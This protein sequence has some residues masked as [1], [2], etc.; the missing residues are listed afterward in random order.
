MS[1]RVHLLGTGGTIAGAQPD[2]RHAGYSAGVFPI[3]RLLSAVPGLAELARLSWEQIVN[4]GSQDMD[5]SIWLALA[6]RVNEHADGAAIDALLITHG[7][8]TLEETAYF[9]SLVTAN[10]T[11]VVIVGAMR[12]ATAISADGPGN[13]YN[14]VAVAADP[15][16]PGR[17]TLLCMDGEIHRPRYAV[18]TS[19]MGANAF[20]SL[21]GGLVGVVQTGRVA[22]F[23]PA[24]AIRAATFSVAGLDRLPR[25]DVLIAHAGMNADL[26]DAA[27]AAG[28]RGLVIAGV[29]SGNMSA[30]AIARLADAAA[31]GVAV[32]RSSRVPRSM[33]LRNGE[34]DDDRYGFVA[35]R[36]LN[37]GKSRVLLQLALTTTND[38]QLIQ[39]VFERC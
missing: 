15:R 3:E 34:V 2:P 28:A 8:D 22:W 33:V 12:P 20:S 26:I 21:L 16:A 17:G 4:I 1:R 5:D 14:G 38:T 37:P 30:R 39:E 7:T 32:V 9:L 13:L 35:A 10:A 23:E 25:V 19:T 18:K 29:G 24:P 11:P 31:S 36:D 27:V 6:T